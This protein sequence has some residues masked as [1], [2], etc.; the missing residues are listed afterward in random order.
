MLTIV[1]RWGSYS[2]FA[3]IVFGCAVQQHSKILTSTA[4]QPAEEIAR[5]L[6][7]QAVACWQKEPGFFNNGVRVRGKRSIQG[8]FV[9]TA[10]VWVAGDGVQNA[11]LIVEVAETG[12]STSEILVSGIDTPDNEQFV[13]DVGRW[14]QGE[15]GCDLSKSD[16]QAHIHA[17]DTAT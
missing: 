3:I 14:V 4:R 12:P 17:S 7:K 16:K 15:L 10:S 11:F 13:S 6:E 1:G 5:T 8:T 2:A 9:V